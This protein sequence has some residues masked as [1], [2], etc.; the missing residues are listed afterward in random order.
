MEGKSMS[1]KG[2]P[3][4]KATRVGKIVHYVMQ[5]LMSCRAAIVTRQHE[6]NLLDLWVLPWGPNGPEAVPLVEHE[7]VDQAGGSW[8]KR[9]DCEYGRHWRERVAEQVRLEQR[10]LESGYTDIDHLN[11]GAK[12]K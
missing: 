2:D 4:M 9:R 6:G 10:A 12:A 1:R 3:T 5:D 11:L 7:R 8:H